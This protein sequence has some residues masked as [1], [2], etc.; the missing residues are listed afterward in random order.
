MGSWHGMA[1]DWW[2]IAFIG[3]HWDSKGFEHLVSK[4]LADHFLLVRLAHHFVSKCQPVNRHKVEFWAKV[5]SKAVTLN[6]IMSASLQSKSSVS[7]FSIQV[8]SYTQILIYK[9]KNLCADTILYIWVLK[10]AQGVWYLFF[11]KCVL[12]NTHTQTHTD[13][14]NMWSVT[15][16]ECVCACVRACVSWG[17]Q[18][19]PTSISSLLSLAIILHFAPQHPFRHTIQKLLACTLTY[20]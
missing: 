5:L 17:F 20:T 7:F 10:N 6:D 2:L 12:H 11:S 9:E 18:N 14:V 13:T 15:V 19:A 3:I 8:L 4:A 1:V 16:A